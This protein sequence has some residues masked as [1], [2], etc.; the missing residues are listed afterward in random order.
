MITVDEDKPDMCDLCS[1]NCGELRESWIFQEQL[2]LCREEGEP[3][4]QDDRYFVETCIENPVPLTEV[5]LAQL[6]RPLPDMS[7]E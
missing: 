7:L 2:F 5:E 6:R 4:F 1:F 3:N